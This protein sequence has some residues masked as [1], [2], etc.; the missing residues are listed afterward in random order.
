M[1]GIGITLIC[2]A[3]ARLGPSKG[4][5]IAVGAIGGLLVLLALGLPQ[6]L[7]RGVI[8]GFDA[9][10][11]QAHQE[12]DAAAASLLLLTAGKD[13]S[14]LPTRSST[15]IPGMGLFSGLANWGQP[16]AVKTYWRHH[17]AATIYAI[18]AGLDAGV[19]DKGALQLA[20]SAQSNTDLLALEAEL[21]KMALELSP[22]ST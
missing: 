16:E 1:A 9:H 15:E 19:K 17:S 21:F 11:R 22:S 12:S 18:E 5:N 13:L 14:S 4:W 6:R 8:R 20:Q 10:V 7:G 2:A 3:L